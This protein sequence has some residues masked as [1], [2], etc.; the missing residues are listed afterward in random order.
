MA[1][2]GAGRVLARVKLGIPILDDLLPEGI[3]R[4]SMVVIAGD[5]G[6][7]KSFF[8]TLIA[9]S[10][11]ERGEKVIYVA[12]DDDPITIV[13][14][15]ESSRMNA[16][17]LVRGE[18][19]ILVDGYGPRYGVEPE[20]FVKAAL[21]DIDPDRILSTVSRISD[22]HGMRCSGLLVL[23]SLNPLLARYEATRVLD[24]VNALRAHMA[25]KRGVLSIA[26]LHTPT[27]FYSEV[28]ANLEYMVDV[29]VW[30]Q[31][32]REAVAQGYPVKQLLVKKARGVPVQASW[33]PY[34]I[35]KEGVIPI[36]LRRRAGASEEGK[37]AETS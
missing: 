36:K 35:T 26:T 12:L 22:E 3:L 18:E 37:K 1:L 6:V 21:Q 17:E 5:G 2:S 30:M 11:L 8:V 14:A 13:S 19:L 34:M 27:Q 10:F 24:F 15:L 25:K 32:Y 9:A 20:S 4:R 23:D 7:G 16:M 28:A 29:F 31:H 33:I